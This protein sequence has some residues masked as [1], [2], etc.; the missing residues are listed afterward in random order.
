MSAAGRFA[1]GYGRRA[2]KYAEILDPTLL[3]V[4]R[5]IVSLA[6][7]AKG[8]RVLDLATGTG[9]VA[10]ELLA[11]GARAVG[12]DVSLGM[13]GVGRRL[14]PPE[15]ELL[16]GDAADLPFA[17]DTFGVVTCCLGISHMPRALAVLAEVRRVLRAGG[18]L[19]IAAWGTGGRNP[20]FSAIQQVIQ[21][22]VTGSIQAFEG[23]LD[24]GTWA[25]PERGCAIL[26][27]AGFDP[28]DIISE[29]VSGRFTGAQAAVDWAFSW[30]NYGETLDALGASHSALVLAE[31]EL[32][33]RAAG[34]LDWRYPVNYSAATKP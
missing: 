24:E 21:R 17:A 6:A 18:R 34:I 8:E 12:L 32:A 9:A 30:P 14:G 10:R 29:S 7:P 15:V 33:V 26:R 11:A 31:A 27:A 4:V 19:L 20:A 3:P 16:I 25:D 23:L 5:R 22:H 13:I 1:E 2:E 28:V